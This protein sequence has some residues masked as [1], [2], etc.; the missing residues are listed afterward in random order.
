MKTGIFSNELREKRVST[1]NDKKKVLK[2]YKLN[3]K[4]RDEKMSQMN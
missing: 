4:K 3:L 1:K 2:E